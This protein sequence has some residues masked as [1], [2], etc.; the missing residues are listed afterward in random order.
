M[1]EQSM[2]LPWQSA[3]RLVLIAMLVATALA[4]ADDGDVIDYRQHI[5]NTLEEQSQALGLI[6]SGAVPDDNAVAHLETLALTASTAL[7]AFEPRVPGGRA[8]PDVWKN[9][10]DFAKRM[11]DFAAKTTE[12]VKTA[13]A[14]GARAGLDGVADGLTCKGCHDLY[15]EAKK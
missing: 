15:R 8:K 7:K 2:V 9:W 4:R 11:N 14:R 5:M 1:K 6:L 3:G 12:L 10:A 13:K